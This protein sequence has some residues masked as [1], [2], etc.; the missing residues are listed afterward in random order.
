[1]KFPFKNL[2]TMVPIALCLIALPIAWGAEEPF[3]LATSNPVQPIPTEARRLALESAEAFANDGFRIR[4]AEWPFTLGTGNPLFLQVT[5]FT[6]NR[7]W[8]VTATPTPGA[9]L[10]VTL[11]DNLGKPLKTQQWEDAG[12]HGG[13]RAAAGFAPELSGR[14]FV[15]VEIIQASTDLPLD[16]SLVIAYK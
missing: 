3:T 11:Y 5:L 2:A 4:D 15:G 7:Y 6:G 12:A 13:S 8:F 9:K 10:R 16:C 14:Y 1:M